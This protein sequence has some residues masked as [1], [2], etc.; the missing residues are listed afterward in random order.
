MPL[1]FAKVTMVRNF[2]IVAAG[3]HDIL[4]VATS[5]HDAEWQRVNSYI[6]DVLKDSHVL[7]AKLAR[8][9]GDFDGEEMARLS[10]ISEA[11]LAI[12]DELST[13][14]KAFY[15]GKYQ[16]LQSEFS[17]GGGE[18]GG[19]GAP[20]APQ[21]GSPQ[22]GAPQGGETPPAP[23]TGEAPPAPPPAPGGEEAP[24]PPPPEDEEE[25]EEEDFSGEQ[26]AA[27]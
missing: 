2:S 1:I 4:K 21:G 27:Q 5:D 16:M 14:S 12:G 25:E 23:P 10:R 8:L 18:G 15:E 20:G 22:G 9:Q 13:F 24:P 6:A 7:Y 11:V 3:V 17:Y 26:E 19:G